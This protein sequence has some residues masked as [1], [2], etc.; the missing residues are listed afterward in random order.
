MNK[1]VAMPDQFHDIPISLEK[2]KTI[3]KKYPETKTLAIIYIS[4][5]L[6]NSRVDITPKAKS[7][8]PSKRSLF[9][10]MVILK[11]IQGLKGNDSETTHIFDTNEMWLA[12]AAFVGMCIYS[13]IPFIV[14]S[15]PTFEELCNLC[16]RNNIKT[17]CLPQHIFLR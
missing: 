6:K 11:M 17:V 2:L 13:A 4:K 12:T 5:A 1:V 14:N 8:G 7:I 16:V 15:T 3:V 9:W 10:A